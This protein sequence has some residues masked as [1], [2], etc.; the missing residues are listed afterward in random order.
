M[1]FEE[2]EPV[3]AWWKDRMENGNAWKV[4]VG[5][6]VESGY[7]LDIKNPSG[8]ADLEHLPPEQLTESILKKAEDRRDNVG[9]Q[10]GAGRWD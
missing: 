9:D 10:I 6:I 3:I 4:P 8:K 7:N 2:F 1:P 5:K